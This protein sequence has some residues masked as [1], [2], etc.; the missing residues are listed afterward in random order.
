MQEFSLPRKFNWELANESITPTPATS[1]SC[2]EKFTV[3]PNTLGPKVS[4]RRVDNAP[5]VRDIIIPGVLEIARG[6]TQG[7]Y[8]YAQQEG[9]D[10]EGPAGTE[11]NSNF[12]DASN[13]GWNQLGTVNDRTFDTW[14]NSLN[15]NVGQN[16]IGK[17][18][19]MRSLNTGQIFLI[20]FTQWS[21]GESGGKGG[22]AYDRYEVFPATN[23]YRPASS[24][25]TVDII[26][27][28]LILKRDNIRGIYNFVLE[29]E[30]NRDTDLSPLGTEWNSS[31]IDENLN[32]WSNLNNVRSRVYGSW[33]DAINNNPLD[34]VNNGLQLVM[35]DLSTD[36]YWQFIFTDW[37][38]GEGGGYGMMQYTRTLIVEDCGITFAN[39]AFMAVP[40]IS[41]GPVVDADGNL[42]TA[43]SSNDLVNVDK[44]ASHS[45][46]NFSGM[47]LVN[48]HYDGRVE[49]W[50]AGGGD[51]V[52]LGATNLG[53]RPCGSTLTMNGSGYDWTNVDELTGPF[54]FTV[55]KTR[56]EA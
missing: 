21:V 1:L 32:G 45:I 33:K 22:F 28:G 27:E 52:L 56:N 2:G 43:N 46:N 7:I 15:N 24:P 54:T 25:N 50:I 26:S 9:W 49:T 16:I 23:F 40:P 8:N 53:G 11:W 34:A 31:Y 35:H 19:V 51:T 42:I 47:L 30:Y 39:G 44:G 20:I 37:G 29:T 36:L 48:D 55:I 10:N 6:N 3:N 12:T 5:N 38:S 17:Q 18:L 41:S 13:Y 4:F 14:K